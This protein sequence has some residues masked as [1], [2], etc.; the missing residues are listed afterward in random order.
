MSD[1]NKVLILDDDPYIVEELTEFLQSHG[2]TCVS[3]SDA[4]AAI[5]A[6]HEDPQIRL[7]LSDYRMPDI[8]GIELIK[9]LSV[10]KPQE[11]IF[12]SILF[13]ADADKDDIICALRI[14]IDDYYQKPLELQNLLKGVNRLLAEVQRRESEQK[15]GALGER[16]K[17][18]SNS[19]QELQQG[20][21]TLSLNSQPPA[22]PELELERELPGS[23]LNL[24]DLPGNAKL[25]PRQ[26]EVTELLAQGL[27]NYQISCQLGI[28][29]NTVKLYVSQV[30]RATNMHSRTLLALALGGQSRH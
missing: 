7:V 10:T 5:D 29:E 2:I 23:R 3:C 12:A 28:S 16:L 13:T 14:G 21:E 20:V 18:M 6:F 24:D 22:E 17:E 15:L 4:R 19:L 30:L 26:L 9:L 1:L 11:R 25:T 27:T 8:N